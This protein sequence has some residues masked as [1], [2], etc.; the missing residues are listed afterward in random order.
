MDLTEYSCT[1]ISAY[2]CTSL[3]ACHTY[4]QYLVTN[5]FHYHCMVTERVFR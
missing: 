5:S 1:A 4:M 2:L 3:D